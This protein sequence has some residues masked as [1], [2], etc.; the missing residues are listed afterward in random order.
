VPTGEV[1][2]ATP[3]GWD[4]YIDG[5][6]VG[7]GPVSKIVSVGQHTFMVKGPGGATA[8]KTFD[9][10]SGGT[11]ILKVPPPQGETPTG[12]VE[13]RTIPSGATVSADGNPIIGQTPTSFRLSVGRHIL[14]ISLYPFRPVRQEV[15]VKATG[16]PPVEVRL[17]R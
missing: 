3:P 13:V 2:A 15:E 7:A 8:E 4:V 10:K 16:T 1:Y 17:E 9:V 12:V 11:S 5:K 14:V 6:L